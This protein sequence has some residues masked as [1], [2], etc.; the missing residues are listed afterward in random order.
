MLI[1]KILGLIESHKKEVGVSCISVDMQN[2]II[3]LDY[4]AKSYRLVIEEIS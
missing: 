2:D 1:E 4:R 3:N